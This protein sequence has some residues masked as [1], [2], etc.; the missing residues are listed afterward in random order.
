MSKFQWL[1]MPSGAAV[2][3]GLRCGLSMVLALWLAF[4]LELDQPYWAMLNTGILIKPM[5]G[6]IGQEF[7]RANPRLRQVFDLQRRAN[8]LAQEL[9]DEA[10]QMANHARVRQG[11]RAAVAAE[12]VASALA[13]Y[14]RAYNDGQRYEMRLGNY[15]Y[16]T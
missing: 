15:A 11:V 16:S 14:G 7:E 9:L 10:L 4:Y 12:L 6:A 5:L 13:I 8:Q 1:L 2:S 3:F